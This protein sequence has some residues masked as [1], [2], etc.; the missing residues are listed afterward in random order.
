LNTYT[1]VALGEIVGFFNYAEIMARPNN[2]CRV[3]ARLLIQILVVKTPRLTGILG[4]L[5][6]S[7]RRISM[8]KTLM[9]D[10]VVL[11]PGITG[12]VLQHNG[13]DLWGLSGQAAW[14]MLVHLGKDF[15]KLR[16]VQDD[17]DSDD[18][19]D[20]IRA[21]R[22]MPDV[23]IVPGLIKIDGYSKTAN[24]IRDNFQIV[25]GKIGDFAAANFYEF[26]Y[27]W[28]RDNRVAA[29]H[30]KALID[31]QLP[32]WRKH[33]YDNDAKVILIGHSMGGLVARH[34]LEVLEGENWRNCK[35][36]IT[37]G[38]PYRGAP[39]AVNYM[40][41]GYKKLFVDLT[42]VMRG[43]TSMYQLLPIYEAIKVDGSFQRVAETAGIPGIDLDRAKE[44]LA[45]HR[46]I[47]EAVHQHRQDA[48]YRSGG[49]TII[50]YVGTRQ[51]TLQSAELQE[52][53]LMASRSAPGV[54]PEALS[55]GDGTVPRVSAIPIE[56]SD[57]Y[58]ETYEPE[59]HGSLQSNRGILN[60]LCERLRRMQ[61]PS[62]QAIRGPEIRPEPAAIGLDV[63]DVYLPDEP[64]EL[65]VQLFNFASSS[66]RLE[67]VVES[68]EAGGA[69]PICK[70]FSGEDEQRII[71]LE[72]L[73]HGA[74]RVEVRSTD[75]APAAPNPVHALFAV[76]GL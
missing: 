11:L 63:E 48:D 34:Y 16:L 64:V 62:L 26:P 37:F 46:K 68:L 22:V 29:R 38:T 50:P 49:Y 42:E 45:F 13:K 43:F 76:A 27:D 66:S 75:P 55:D 14:R 58:R 30:L 2:F 4:Y 44:A 7:K 57:K 8:A 60:D 33:T 47:E 3:Y 71:T 56:L 72:G 19:G 23:H 61:A 39:N 6:S 41:N 20:G 59:Q 17:L 36:L 74:Y 51:P 24:M 21:T 35:A 67:A 15:D 53:R 10:L 28:R 25:E 73:A 70:P 52:G 1:E 9:R 69:E 65:R 32:A 40:A 12:S 18:L 31:R 54:V 5:C